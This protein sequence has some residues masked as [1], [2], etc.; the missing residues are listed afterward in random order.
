MGGSPDLL[1]ESLNSNS[2]SKPW[3]S[4]H[5]D[6]GR[7]KRASLGTLRF[8][9]CEIEASQGWNGRVSATTVFVA[10]CR[11]LGGSLAAGLQ[12]A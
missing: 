12:P 3:A 6:Q 4:A 1:L 9:C 10:K 11:R 8:Y 7:R 2:S 5:T